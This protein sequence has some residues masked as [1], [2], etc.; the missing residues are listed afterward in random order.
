MRSL[1]ICVALPAPACSLQPQRLVSSTPWQCCL[2]NSSFHRVCAGIL[3]LAVFLFDEQLHFNV[4]NIGAILLTI[5]MIL[6][7]LD[8]GAGGRA[9]G[10]AV[11]SSAVWGVVLG[12]IIVGHLTLTQQA[13]SLMT[14]MHCCCTFD[15][16]CMVN[17]QAANH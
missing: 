1:S 3:L 11:L 7:S 14:C 8:L 16:L 10:S 5:P 12:G 13:C 15:H 9:F 17:R 6:A 2:S 4:D